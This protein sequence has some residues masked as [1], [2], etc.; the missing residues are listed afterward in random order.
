MALGDIGRTIR[1]SVKGIV[2]GAGDVV[3]GTAETVRD[4]VS[5]TLRGAGGRSADGY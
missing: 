2:S 4:A 3:E 1:D 5:G